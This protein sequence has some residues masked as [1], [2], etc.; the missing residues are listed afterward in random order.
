MRNVKGLLSVVAGLVLLLQAGTTVAWADEKGNNGDV[1]IHDADTAQDDHRNEPHV[2]RFYVDG[3]N[4]D[5]NSSGTWRIERQ[6]PTGSG[7]AVSGTWGPANAQGNWRTAVMTLADGHYKLFAKQTSPNTVGGEKQKVFWVDCAAKTQPGAP[8]GNTNGGQGNN[9]NSGQ[10]PGAPTKSGTQSRSKGG[11]SKSGT[12]SKSKGK[13]SASGTM[14]QSK[15][16]AQAPTTN[17]PAANAPATNTPNNNAGNNENNAA[18]PVVGGVITPPM[19]NNQ[20]A[21]AQPQPEVQASRALA[22]VQALPS[23]STDSNAPMAL[24]GVLLIGSGA[25][26]LRRPQRRMR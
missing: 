17:A 3:F 26:L 4:F 13:A 7:V 10:Q 22:G 12:G 23:T 14:S 15:H 1:K 6:A 8:G 5:K 9:G 21:A 19:N 16:P 18:Q 25:Y 11:G 20:Q 24:L 2:C